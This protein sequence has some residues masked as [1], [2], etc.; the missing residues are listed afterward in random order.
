MKVDLN[1]QDIETE[2]LRLDQFWGVWAITD[3]AAAH[4]MQVLRGYDFAAHIRVHAGTRVKPCVAGTLTQTAGETEADTEVTLGIVYIRGELTKY[5]S[6]FNPNGSL[7]AIRRAVRSLAADDAVDAILLLIDSPGGTVAGTAEAAKAVA[8]ART[9]KP[10]WAFIEDLGASAAYWIASQADRVIANDRTASVGSIGTFAALHDVSE[11]AAKEGVRAILFRTGSLK[12]LGFPGAEVTE[13]Q[14]AYLQAH[15]EDIQ[16]SFSEA[17]IAG[18]RRD[19]KWLN[20]LATGRVWL[21]DEAVRLGLIDAIDSFDATVDQLMKLAG[22]THRRPN[23]SNHKGAK[24]M[25]E[26]TTKTPASSEDLLA[27][28]PGADAEF[29]LACLKRKDTLDQAQSAWME[30]QN[31]RLEAA[32]KR[33]EDAEAMAAVRPP[34]GER[35]E[36]DSEK[37][38]GYE[39]A[40]SLWHEKIDEEMRLAGVSRADAATRVNRKYPGLRQAVIDEANP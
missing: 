31:R 32:R 29:V 14:R 33:A 21:A 12:G 28:L 9:A 26:E 40:L 30:E 34:H 23:H 17:V 18:R 16:E 20:P 27:C 1:L 22:G 6:S 13:E 38:G 2:A 25:A 11:K 19:A 37:P 5:G 36:A 4:W 39:N 8:E 15:V 24:P 10:V 3:S 7:V 35:I